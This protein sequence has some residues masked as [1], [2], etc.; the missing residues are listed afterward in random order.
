MV[1]L[2]HDFFI[3]TRDRAIS[4]MIQVYLV[5]KKLVYIFTRIKN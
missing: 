2:K 1:L 3:A 5:H 4:L